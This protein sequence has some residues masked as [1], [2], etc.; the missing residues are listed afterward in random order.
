MTDDVRIVAAS[1]RTP[2]VKDEAREQDRGESRDPDE[3]QLQHL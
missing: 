1:Y 2:Q 3:S